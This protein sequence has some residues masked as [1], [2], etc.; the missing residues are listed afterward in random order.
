[1]IMYI[2]RLCFHPGMFI[3][4]SD[5]YDNNLWIRYNKQVDVL[6]NVR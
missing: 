6:Q 2:S 5:L 4:E 3:K 1:M